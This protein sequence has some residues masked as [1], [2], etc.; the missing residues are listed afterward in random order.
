MKLSFPSVE[1]AQNAGPRRRLRLR[2]QGVVQG[3]GFRPHVY[4][5]AAEMGV[6]GWVGNA[7]SGVVVEVEGTEA[8]L[9]GFRRRLEMERP[10]GSSIQSLE[11]IWLE[12]AGWE[13]FRIRPSDPTGARTVTVRPDVATCEDCVREIFDSGDRRYQ[14]PFTNC[15]HCGPRYSIIDALPY[16]RANTSM[17]GFVMC[18][19]CQ[20][21]YAD[22]S[23]RRFHAQP[24]AC[25]TCGPRLEMWS[26]TGE[27]W[28][29]G[30]EA[31]AAAAEALRQG[32][33]LAV[34]GLGGFH[35][36]ADARSSLAV[37]TL[38]LRKH[39]EERPLAVMVPGLGDAHALCEVS[40]LE[41]GLLRSPEAPIVLLRRHTTVLTG[42]GVADAVAPGNPFLGLMLPYT[43]LHHLLLAELRFPVVATS[44]NLSDEPICID[45]HEALER[46]RGIADGFLVHNRPILRHVDDSVVR[47]VAGR[48]MMVR[49][50]RGYAP[51]PVTLADTTG[52][53]AAAGNILAV[54]AQQK[55]A[56]ALGSAG[57]IVLSQH[58]GDLDT[59]AAL[60]V[61]RRVTADL[62]RL[63]AIEPEWVVSDLH[64]DYVSTREAKARSGNHRGVQHHFAHVLSCMAENEL[65][66]P[67]LGIAWDGTGY[68][69]DG[70]IWGGEFL[71]ADRDGYDRVATLRPFRLPGGERAIREPR[72]SAVGL[73]FEHCGESAFQLTDVP[74]VA[75]FSAS[76][77]TAIQ[78]ALERRFNAPQTTAVGRLF[79]AVA[80]LVGIRQCVGFEG[81]AAMALEWLASGAPA[82]APYQFPLRPATGTR[83]EPRVAARDAVWHADWAPMIDELLHDL[84]GGAP[85]ARMAVRFHRALIEL[86]VE[87][88]TRAGLERVALSG[89]CFQNLVLLEGIIERLRMAG[90]RV[91]WH[92][93]VPTHDGGLALGQA[94]AGGRGGGRRGRA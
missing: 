68:G 26:A 60:T 32:Q 71:L 17:K 90:H 76:E 78:G 41:E 77:L 64:P 28:G 73:L 11:T 44:G 52:A 43:P 70:M 83:S 38:R 55:N 35:L 65:E 54:G 15:T 23:N 49:R 89:G 88:A 34:K 51:L 59:A 91:Y 20:A 82:A 36:M 84:R 21:E 16:D 37:E 4:R 66:G 40:G 74:A 46:L 62:Q 50:A 27:V 72:R 30:S 39:R 47:L 42:E 61:F 63:L 24:N 31:L 75:A 1:N 81:Q 5:L 94:L 10:R 22:P 56:V 93:R 18:A 48:E 92:Q 79:D 7:L 25:P 2:V 86:T 12:P 85:P 57:N 13:G 3:V 19:D 53:P 69:L 80:A 67:L 6:C 9:R 45:E 58:I 29:L 14:Y 87:V 33:I 8:E